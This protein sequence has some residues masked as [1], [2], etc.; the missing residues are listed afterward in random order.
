MT[1]NESLFTMLEAL[2][3]RPGMYLGNKSIRLLQAFICGYFA[4]YD[5][6]HS[7]EKPAQTALFPLD[8]CY[9]HEVARIKCRERRGA[10]GWQQFILSACGGNEEKAVDLF[11]EY[12]DEYLALRA[13]RVKKA[14][15]TEEK[16]SE[17]REYR[18]RQKEQGGI[19][20]E[21]I[22]P[23]AVYHIEL[24]GGLGW[25]C[26]VEGAE[27]VHTDS[28]IYE[29]EDDIGRL[30]GSLGCIEGFAE[31]DMGE[32]PDFGKPVKV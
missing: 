30:R 2:R 1:R 25:L 12:Y 9:M 17:Y 27:E 6:G 13:A 23:Q 7:A 5:T 16:I 8:F 19:P 10:N 22:F 3:K 4:G 14:V 24:T 20:R 28:S 18:R 29:S 26:A 21:D 11:F 32:N 31:V 15:L